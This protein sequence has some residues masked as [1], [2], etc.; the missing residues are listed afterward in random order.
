[1]L[2]LEQLLATSK[3]A[4]FPAESYEKVHALLLMLDLLAKH[5]FAAGKL[6][7]KG[8][9][10]LNIFVFDVPRLSVDIDLNYVG[11]V[12]RDEMLK[13]R[14]GIEKAV[15]DV[16]GR[17]KFRVVRKPKA[18]AGGK[19]VLSYPRVAGGTGEVQLDI[20]YTLRTPLWPTGARDS[21]PVGGDVVPFTLLDD[22]ELAAGKLAAT[23][24]RSA[25]RDV[26]DTR[27][28]LKHHVL[29]DE[30]LR[31]GFVLYGSWNEVDWLTVTPENVT[32]T[33][34][35]VLEQLAPL[36]P[37]RLRPDAKT[38]KAWTEELVTEARALMKRVLPLNANEREFIERVNTK[39]ASRDRCQSSS[40]ATIRPSR[41]ASSRPATSV[42]ARSTRSGSSSEPR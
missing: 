16:A 7:L 38:A 19:W 35:D 13:E 5:P 20:I 2:T 1:M 23:V 29:D 31:L 32:T 27:E 33:S 25:S 21:R 10:A 18:H 34:K 41:A 15:E 3:A 17:L 4:G 30:K 12:S 6:A 22:H 37:E 39:A 9:T 36:L 14:P 24:A 8:G 11:A 28:L 42:R 26:F 40:P